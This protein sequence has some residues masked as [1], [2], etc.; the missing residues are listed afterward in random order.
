MK[1][2]HIGERVLNEAQIRAG[3]ETV[4]EKLNNQF[5]DA[6]VIT[7]V[8]GGILFTADL[9]RELKFDIK[10]DYISCPH[11][12][13]VSH[14]QSRI[15]Y[16]EN[17][18]LNGKDVIM[19]DDAI[20]SGGTMKRLV[21]HIQEHY[22]V[23]SLS[24]ATLFVKPGRVDLPVPQYYAYEMDNDDLLVGYGLPWQDKLRNIPYVSKLVK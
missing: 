21:A 24:I 12:P 4:A 3:V 22:K 6:V 1:S 7:V 23:K 19:I 2:E 8:P 9:V 15:V 5:S 20:E 13:G 11:T 10:M 18:P 16:H 14:N 17:I